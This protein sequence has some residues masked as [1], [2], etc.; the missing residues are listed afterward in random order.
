MFNITKEILYQ[1]MEELR[2]KLFSVGL[3][4]PFNIFDVCNKFS[5]L[6]IEAC[7][8]TTKGLRGIAALAN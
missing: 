6:G 7:P 4:Q 3:K 8:F 2:N 5:D 1:Q